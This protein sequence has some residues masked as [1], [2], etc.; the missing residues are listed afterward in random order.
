MDV[1]LNRFE[2]GF[3]E[4]S[5]GHVKDGS[6]GNERL[7]S[8]GTTRVRGSFQHIQVPP[9]D[10]IEDAFLDRSKEGG[11]TKLPE[12]T[13]ACNDPR[14]LLQLLHTPIR[15]CILEQSRSMRRETHLIADQ[16]SKWSSLSKRGTFFSRLDRGP[17]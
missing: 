8:P 16:V 3:G 7:V 11:P 14:D 4:A 6:P 12:H 17:G 13:K 5:C 15:R 1:V 10:L 2:E 9:V